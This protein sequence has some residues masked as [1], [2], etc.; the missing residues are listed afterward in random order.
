MSDARPS[1]GRIFLVS[2]IAG[3][4]AAAACLGVLWLIGAELSPAVIGG[5]VGGTVGAGAAVAAVR[6]GRR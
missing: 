5:I 4:A 3:V 1:T 6:S 2:I